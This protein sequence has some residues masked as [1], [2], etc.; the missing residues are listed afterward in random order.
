[1]LLEVK[2]T[3]VAPP[4]CQHCANRKPP[5]ESPPCSLAQLLSSPKE[6]EAKAEIDGGPANNLLKLEDSD[7]S[8]QRLSRGTGLG[9]NEQK[10]FL[11]V[12]E[13]VN[14]AISSAAAQLPT[15]Y[16]QTVS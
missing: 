14:S 9:H 5:T 4:S 15:S 11:G 7:S 8:F 1:M 6:A 13:A 10:H 12:M 3:F 16:V 2:G